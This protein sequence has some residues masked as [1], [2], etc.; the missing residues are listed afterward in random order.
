MENLRAS[1][2]LIVE[3][4]AN[5]ILL[6]Q[7]AFQRTNLSIPF[8]V[9]TDGDA[10][11]DYL[12]GEGRYSDRQKYPYPSL[13]LLDL[14]LPRRSGLEVLEWLKSQPLLRRIPVIVLTSSQE[15]KDVD[16]AY[17]AGVSSYLIKPVT[18]SALEKV[19]AALNQYWIDVNYYS[20]IP[21]ST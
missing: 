10:A 21:F 6:L 13:I 17:E 4:D 11:V 15:N 3:D 12:V 5:D 8:N 1:G 9:V 16:R 14:K 18:F 19:M 7:R 2:M 20:S